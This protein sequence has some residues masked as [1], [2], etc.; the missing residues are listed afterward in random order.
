M[1][2]I[3]LFVFFLAEWNTKEKKIMS[4]I[5]LQGHIKIYE[6]DTWRWWSDEI[7]I[8]FEAIC[9]ISRTAYMRQMQTQE[10]FY[11]NKRQQHLQYSNTFVPE[12]SVPDS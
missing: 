6:K 10:I 3:F 8:L 4:F 2:A 11:R 1:I 12:A 5:T 9:R 7:H